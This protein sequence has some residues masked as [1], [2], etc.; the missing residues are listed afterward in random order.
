MLSWNI[1]VE[2]YFHGEKKSATIYSNQKF[3][4]NV[5]RENPG[6]SNIQISP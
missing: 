4:M 2:F 6:W 5:G 3:G 1:Y